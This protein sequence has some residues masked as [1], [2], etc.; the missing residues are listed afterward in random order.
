M[1]YGKD[2]TQ[3]Q[4]TLNPGGKH[5]ISMAQT[6]RFLSKNQQALS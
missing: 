3:I 2:E 1:N 5:Q 6:V 4:K